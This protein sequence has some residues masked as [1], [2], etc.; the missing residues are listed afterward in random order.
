[1]LYFRPRTMELPIIT[2]T[3]L[4]DLKTICVGIETNSRASF[5]QQFVAVQSRQIKSIFLRVPRSVAWA[6]ETRGC[7]LLGSRENWV[8]AKYNPE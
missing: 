6:R 2:V 3:S 5:V 8:K 4:H 7:G 1:M